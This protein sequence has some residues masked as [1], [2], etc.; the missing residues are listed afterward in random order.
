MKFRETAR[1]NEPDNIKFNWMTWN[2]FKPKISVVWLNINFKSVFYNS[3][4]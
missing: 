1:V 2:V 3:F 4:A